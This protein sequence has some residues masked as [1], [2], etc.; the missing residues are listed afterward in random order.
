MVRACDKAHVSR[1]GRALDSQSEKASMHDVLDADKTSLYRLS[2]WA[3]DRSDIVRCE[4]MLQVYVEPKSQWFAES[5]ACGK[6]REGM[7]RHWVTF[8]W[9]TSPSRLIVRSDSQ[10][11]GRRQEHEEECVSWKH[12]A[13]WG[14]RVAAQQAIGTENMASE[15]G[16]HLDAM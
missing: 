5:Q 3:V 15:L 13:L 14:C 2:Y 4:S 8:E 11:L 16:V 6:I 10:W 1:C 9:Q 7:S 12:S